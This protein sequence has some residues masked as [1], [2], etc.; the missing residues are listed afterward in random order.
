MLDQADHDQGNGT[1]TGHLTR[2]AARQDLVQTFIERMFQDFYANRQD[3]A[4]SGGDKGEDYATMYSAQLTRMLS[5]AQDLVSAKQFH[6]INLG[7]GPGATTSASV[8]RRLVKLDRQP[9]GESLEGLRLLRQAWDMVDLCLYVSSWYKLL[10]KLGFLLMLVLAAS[11]III[12]TAYNEIE[13][14]GGDC[15]EDMNEAEFGYTM[16]GISIAITALAAV[17]AYLNPVSR[18]KALRCVSSE[19]RSTIFQ[20]RTRTGVYG[21]WKDDARRYVMRNAKCEMLTDDCDRL[22]STRLRDLTPKTPHP[23]PAATVLRIF[24][25][26][27]SRGLARSSPAREIFARHRLRRTRSKASTSTA[28]KAL[29]SGSQSSRRRR[30]WASS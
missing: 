13:D 3:V 18:W 4:E 25:T 6:C 9:Q 22:V 15:G 14:F 2:K 24:S 30:K 10:A 11:T 21:Q 7:V 19:L 23:P 20:Y 12:T 28:N 1:E 17:I 5:I 26:T 27:P 16:A 29:N 8:L